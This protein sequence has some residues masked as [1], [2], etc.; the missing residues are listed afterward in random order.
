MSANFVNFLKKTP[1]NSTTSSD[2]H[3]SSLFFNIKHFEYTETLSFLEKSMLFLSNQDKK[4]LRHE[5][6]SGNHKLEFLLLRHKKNTDKGLLSLELKKFLKEIKKNPFFENYSAENQK[7]KNFTREFV[8]PTKKTKI[9]LENS[10]NLHIK[11][12]FLKN[13]PRNARIILGTSN[14]NEKNIEYPLENPLELSTKI[15]DFSEILKVFETPK[16]RNFSFCIYK[17]KLREKLMKETAFISKIPF[18]LQTENPETIIEVLFCEKGLYKI[19]NAYFRM[20]IGKFIKAE[21]KEIEKREFINKL[22]EICD[23]KNDGFLEINEIGLAFE[24]IFK[25]DMRHNVKVRDLWRKLDEEKKNF[26]YIS[27]IKS[28]QEKTLFCDID[29]KG[30][31]TYWDLFLREIQ[32]ADLAE[33]L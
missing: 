8:S 1:R 7:T 15:S 23:L 3:S 27:E 19:S 9:D 22:F 31:L 6:K 25:S 4:L 11:K 30:F 20:K 29:K 12:H 24:L 32:E 21:I 28:K 33:T 14:E 5:L 13:K 2:S 16:A 10:E 17:E 18:F 26:I